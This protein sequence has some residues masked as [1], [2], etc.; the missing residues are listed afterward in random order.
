LTFINDF[1]AFR[2]KGGMEEGES[3]EKSARQEK[4]KDMRR[5]E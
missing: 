4:L 1:K 2:R 3:R 5:R